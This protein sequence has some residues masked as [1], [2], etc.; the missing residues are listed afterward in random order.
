MDLS[1]RG[2]QQKWS[3]RTKE[4][5]HLSYEETDRAGGFQP[6]DWKAVGMPNLSLS[7]LKAGQSLK[8][9][10]SD[11]IHTLTGIGQVEIVLNKKRRYFILDI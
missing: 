10:E 9:R 2:G 6:A 3:W 7:V 8:E 1:E 4:L 5:E 11:C